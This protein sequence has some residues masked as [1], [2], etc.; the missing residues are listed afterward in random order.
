MVGRSGSSGQ[1]LAVETAIG[2]IEPRFGERLRRR[3]IVDHQLHAAGD[4]VGQRRRAALVGHMR[5]LDAGH[6]LEQFGRDMR[7]AAE[8][9]RAVE[10][11]ARL[12]LGV[13]DEFRD[14]FH[15]QRI[16]HRKQVRHP[17]DDDDRRDVLGLVVGHVLEHELVDGVGAR[18]ADHEGVA[19]GLGLR[20]E[21]G[22]DVAAGAG[23][24][25]DD[26]LLT[27]FFRD[28]GGDDPRQH[29]GGAAGRERNDSLTGRVGHA[30]ARARRG[31]RDSAPKRG[32]CRS[33][34]SDGW[35]ASG[36]SGR[37]WRSFRD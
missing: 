2:R 14:R 11:F 10:Q 34:G 28:F 17:R 33:A 9:G 37:A 30:C 4:Q 5:H 22:G 3:Q 8:P 12:R 16:G 32:G 7:G 31:D 25:L 35:G 13:G 18:R 6:R 20:D 26:E 24:V 27:E 21:V 15:R 29:V 19:V 23:L 36:R 1:R